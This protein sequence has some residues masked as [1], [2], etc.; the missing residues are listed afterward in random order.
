MSPVIDATAFL[1]PGVIVM[2]DVHVGPGSSVW[3]QSVIRGD[4]ERIRIG[5]RTNIQD[6]TMVHADP[7]IPCLIGDRVTVGH[8]VIL[9]GC[10]VGDDCLIGMGAILLNSVKVGAGSLIGAG[11]L[12]TERMDVPPGSLVL[13]SP[14]RVV[15][16]L[17]DGM[18]DRLE[19]TWRHYAELARRHAA[20]EFPP[21]PVTSGPLPEILGGSAV[22]DVER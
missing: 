19:R 6:F 3:Y 10:V 7:G 11:A 9:H 15:K 17:G 12:L 1:A 16:P 22:E 13:G 8:R 14:A 20:G 18:R 4:T 21:V 5:A 2:G